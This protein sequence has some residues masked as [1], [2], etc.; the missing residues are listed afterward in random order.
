MK[1]IL[2]R[3]LPWFALLLAC[4]AYSAE[5]SVLVRVTAYWRGEGS[6]E[7]AAWN[8]ARL[9][10]GHCAVDPQ[11]IPYGSTVV[12]P[13][14]DCVAVDTGPAVVSRKSAKSCGRT[15]AQKNALVIDRFFESKQEA[16]EWSDAH[17]HFV[18][19]RVIPPE[20]LSHRTVALANQEAP[21][22]TGTGLKLLI[23]AAISASRHEGSDF[24]QK[25]LDLGWISERV[26][27][28]R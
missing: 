24:V 11:K 16:I 15:A 5:Q 18:T 21:T 17:P 19:V 23:C 13:D 25:T 8:G 3:T 7:A 12:F 22:L 9:R 20:P 1:R 14:M 28:G 26:S 4:P 10:N 27:S 6:G 2:I